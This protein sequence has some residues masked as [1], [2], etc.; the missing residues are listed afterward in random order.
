M[1]PP[2]QAGPC[3][4]DTPERGRSER[5][6]AQATRG[7]GHEQGQAPQYHDR[8]GGVAG[9]ERSR[10]RRSVGCRDV[11][12]GPAD[13]LTDDEEHDE[14]GGGSH[15]DERQVTPAVAPT[16]HGQGHQQSEHDAR[17]VAEA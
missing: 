17:D 9:R 16:G 12:P 5:Y 13:E 6:G 1:L 2:Y 10:Q 3:H 8:D 15:P 14:L 7:R 4:E 11:G